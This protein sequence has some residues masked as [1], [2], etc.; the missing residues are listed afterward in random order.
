MLQEPVHKFKNRYGDGLLLIGGTVFKAEGDLVTFQLF[1]T[2][3]G[4][5]DS[6]DIGRQVF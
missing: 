6:V 5:S 1:N 3:V 2:V 4:D